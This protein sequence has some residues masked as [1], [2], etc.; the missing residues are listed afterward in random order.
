MTQQYPFHCPAVAIRVTLY[1]QTFI[2][3]G[4]SSSA[5]DV[6]RDH[7]CSRAETCPHRYTEACRVYQL[8][9]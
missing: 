3:S 6:Q 8:N 5:A 1:R 7:D 9:R 2:V 4:I